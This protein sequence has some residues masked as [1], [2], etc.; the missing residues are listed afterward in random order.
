MIEHYGL[1]AIDIE[2]VPLVTSKEHIEVDNSFPNGIRDSV[3]MQ[4]DR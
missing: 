4:S 2:W 1:Q 3:A